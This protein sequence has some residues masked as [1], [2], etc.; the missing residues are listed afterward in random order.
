MMSTGMLGRVFRIAAL[1]LLIAAPARADR[2][3]AGA[4]LYPGITKSIDINLQSETFVLDGFASPFFGIFTPR[5]QC[6]V[7]ECL[8][9]TTVNL[10]THFSGGD[11]G[12]TATVDGRTFNTIGSLSSLASM[13]ATWTGSLTI[14]A[15]YQGGFVTGPF[16]FAGVFSYEVDP[17]TAWRNLTLFGSGTATATFRPYGAP[18]LAPALLLDSIRY[19]FDPAPSPEPATIVLTGSAL[20]G[21]WAARARRKRS[22]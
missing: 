1:F 5:F 2:I 9:G 10:L 13:S 20:A 17:T 8:P 18:E 14:P 12:G 4:L 22:R 6:S 3:T 16:T 19:E 15:G 21:L 11:L 7:A